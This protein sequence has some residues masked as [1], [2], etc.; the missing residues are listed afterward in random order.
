MDT[1]VELA[2]NDVVLDAHGATGVLG[3]DAMPVLPVVG[4]TQ[5]LVVDSYV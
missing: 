2:E 4:S 5:Y 1:G 3:V